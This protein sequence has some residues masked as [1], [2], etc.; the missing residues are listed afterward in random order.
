MCGVSY[1]IKDIG[2]VLCC[3][4]QVRQ[5][6]LNNPSFFYVAK[7][8]FKYEGVSFTHS[9]T[10]IPVSFITREQFILNLPKCDIVPHNQPRN[11]NG[12]LQVSGF[13][14]GMYYPLLSAGALNSLFFGVY[15]VSLRAMTERRYDNATGDRRVL[16]RGP[17]CSPCLG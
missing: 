15:G 1:D 12:M 17:T 13:F 3:I 2:C 9:S 4:F 14:K 11:S 6:A 5:Q 7:S 8:C 10:E 16:L